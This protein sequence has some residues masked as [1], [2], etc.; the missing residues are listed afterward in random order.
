M[1]S[2]H[3][4]IAGKKHAVQYRLGTIYAIAKHF[5]AEPA[6]LLQI[7]QSTDTADV[8]ELSAVA[9]LY[10]L[11]T[12]AKNNGKKAPFDSVDMLLD[13][14]DS[15]TELRPA[16][17]CFTEAF[18]KCLGLNTDTATDTGGDEGNALGVQPNP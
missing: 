10:G 1:S 9:T 15:L 3:I 17:E 12:E 18:M 14:V 2:A 11:K 16:V 13:A 5:K 8:I 4:T 6:G 7:M